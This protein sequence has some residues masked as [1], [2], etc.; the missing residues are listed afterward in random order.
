MAK[1]VLQNDIVRIILLVRWQLLKQK[2]ERN[3]FPSLHR[4]IL[5]L[6]F[7]LVK[8]PVNPI[9]CCCCFFAFDV[10]RSIKSRNACQLLQFEIT[11]F[12]IDI[13]NSFLPFL[14]LLF[15][16]S[17]KFNK[18]FSSK[19]VA[20]RTVWCVCAS[21]RLPPICPLDP[22]EEKCEAH[23]ILAWRIFQHLISKQFSFAH[24]PKNI[25]MMRPMFWIRSI[26]FR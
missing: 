15:L 11:I 1:M 16:R 24:K 10:V 8:H 22:N 21:A 14:V 3:F 20:L 12:S 18:F 17:C 19:N 9:I 26:F 2:Y 4:I 7:F 6:L 5:T 25:F 13:F 23:F